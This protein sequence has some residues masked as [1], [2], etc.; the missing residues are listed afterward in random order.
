MTRMGEIEEAMD[1]YLATLRTAIRA[2]GFTQLRVQKRLGWGRSFISQIL[3]RQKGLRLETLLLFLRA[4]DVS[5]EEVVPVRY[6]SHHEA[7]DA[8]RQAQAER[9]P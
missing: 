7:Y 4:L 1:R 6:P 5:P 3:S 2:R 8:L 9:P